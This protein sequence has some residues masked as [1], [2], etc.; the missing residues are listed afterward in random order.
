MDLVEKLSLH[1]TNRIKKSLP[2]KKEVELEQ[3]KY[4]IHVLLNNIIKLPVVFII[5]FFLGILKYTFVAFL[6]FNFVRW[7]ASGIHARKS[8]SCLISTTIVF[9]G[10]ALLG[11]NISLK[12]I[13]IT[14]GFIMCVV[15]AYLYAPA[16]TEEKPYV[17]QRVRGR[18]KLQS[19]ISII[20]LYLACFPLINTKYASIITFSV[21]AECITILPITYII[22]KRRFNNHEV[23]NS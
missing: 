23:S 1:L 12:I 3:I 15:L 22:F 5:A 18:L 21:I 9:I 13:D 8:I 19:C 16:D 6:C 14:A 11:S 20:I 4:G 2:E 7:S 10:V 17:S